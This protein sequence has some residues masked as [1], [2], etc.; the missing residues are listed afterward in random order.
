MLAFC[1]FAGDLR[2][3]FREIIPAITIAAP[4]KIGSFPLE[5]EAYK[6][7]MGVGN[8]ENAYPLSNG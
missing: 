3:C 6:V 1:F 2:A 4:R 5:G 7:G 8:V